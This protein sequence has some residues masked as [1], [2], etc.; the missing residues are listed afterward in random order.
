MIGYL[1]RKEKEEDDVNEPSHYNM[2]GMETIE[3]IKHSTSVDEFEGYLK[4]NVLKYV[5]RYKHKHQENPIKDLLKA[6]WY[7]NRL[8]TELKAHED[9][10]N[11]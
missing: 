4:G 10:Y 3:L 5:S 1:M 6:Q 7:L 2:N 11:R 9:C 8:V